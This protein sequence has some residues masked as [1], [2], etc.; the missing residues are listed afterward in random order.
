M[1]TLDKIKTP[2]HDD[3]KEFEKYFSLSMKSKVPLLGLI[4]NY[5]LRRKGK[6]M[7]PLLVFLTAKLNGKI[8]KST[9]NAAAMIELLHT[10]SLVHDDVVDESYMR[11]GYFSVNAL[12]NSKIA[13]L[14]GDFFYAKG[15]ILAIEHKEYELLRIVSDTAK[16]MSEGELLQI[17]KARK[18]DIT[19]ELYFEI[20]RKKTASLIAA[21][22]EAGVSSVN[23]SID[24][25]EKMKSFGEKL[26][27]AFQ[28]K[29]DLMDFDLN[30][31]S[32]KP[33]GNDLKEKKLT[34]P[35]I[36]AL[37]QADNKDKRKITSLINKKVDKKETISYVIDFVKQNGG[38]AY[39]ETKMNEYKN[40]TVS[41]LN[42]F[43]ENETKSSLLNFIEFAVSRKL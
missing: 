15:L 21:C 38:I 30:N 25:K 14:L 35:L 7:R 31:N 11:R 2:V 13:V 20:I 22:A 43:P 1:L 6:M 19:E 10:A 5:V 24:L 9:H 23:N 29:D 16:E 3:L 39:A 32:G 42:E 8:N 37:Q 26:G 33:T 36:Y 12:W 17:Q 34:L 18:L 41:Y 4:T 40:I 27:I 28:I